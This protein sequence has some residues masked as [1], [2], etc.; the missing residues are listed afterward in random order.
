MT[1]ISEQIANV[2]NEILMV[3]AIYKNPDLLVEYSQYIK[4]K[5]D[6][7]DEVTKFFYDNA[8]IIYKKRSQIFNKATITTFMTEDA[9]R[10]ASYKKYG[11]WSLIESW[12][13]LAIVDNFKN[14]YEILKKYSLLREYQRNGY[15]VEKIIKHPKF[16][17]FS[18]TDIYRLVRGK[19]DRINTVILTNEES[20]ILNTKIVNMINGCLEKPD[21]GITMPF[22]ICN[23]LFRGIKTKT[24]MA[25]GML[26]N[27]GKSRF[28]F[29]LIAYITLVLKEKVMVLLNE[30][31]PEEMR[32][33]LLTT[34]INNREFQKLH[35]IEFNKKE[36]EI[37]L[38]LY[39]DSK[40]DF[41]YR[42]K[43]EWGDFTESVEDYTRRLCNESEEYNNVIK[44]A[45]WIEDE[46]QGIIFA[47][48]VKSAY[49]DKSLEFEIRKAS[50]TQ[51]TKYFFYDTLKSDRD[52]IGE[53]ASFK[54]TA[55][56]LS[57]L[58]DP[59]DI[60]IYGS[61]QLSDDANYIP[62]DELTS[63]QIANAKQI[64]HVLHTLTLFKEI[65]KKDYKKYVYIT[66]N[67][68]W[69]KPIPHE[70]DENKRYYVAV[71]DKNRFG[72]KKKLLFEVDL[73]YNSWYEIGEIYRR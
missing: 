11:G 18:A 53:W 42:E 45:Q 73:N 6:F 67:S 20:E 72:E 21:M 12:E 35:G 44:V 28:M 71:I 55:T 14:Y 24:M 30:M 13:K 10:L 22:P 70:L 33:C 58:T 40:G 56:K 31:T 9:E 68:D 48:D 32:F 52:G 8:E 29:K 23:D 36:K 46:T 60:F 39:K 16:E 17:S 38:G 27:A 65:D 1:K 34:V 2:Q 3:G 26:S 43:D 64:K 61:I 41:I 25:V 59:L 7:H 37:A 49:D 47:K 4:S 69:G 5:Y 66:P 54:A 15:A 62:P 50:L 57:E 19:V 63:S 51:G